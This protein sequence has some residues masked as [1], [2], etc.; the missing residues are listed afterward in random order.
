ML[1]VTVGGVLLIPA[2]YLVVGRITRELG[3]GK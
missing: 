3:G 1:M 2:L